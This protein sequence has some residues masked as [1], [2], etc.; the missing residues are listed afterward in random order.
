[1]TAG[2]DADV[3]V[4]GA[5]IAGCSAAWFAARAGRRVTIVDDGAHRASDLPVALINPL[6][7]ATGRLVDGGLAGMAASFAMID[8]LRARGHDVIAGRGLHRPLVGAVGDVACEPYWRARIG[9]RLRFD[10]HA[11]APASLGLTTPVP[12]LF[13]HDAGWVAS[14]TLLAALL[15]ASDATLVS[16]RVASVVSKTA[17]LV[18]GRRITSRTLLWAAGAWGAALLDGGDADDASYRP[19]SLLAFPS[20]A[21]RHA[22]AFGL[23]AVPLDEGPGGDPTGL[24][25]G[26]TRE[27][28]Q[29]RFPDGDTPPDAV[30][31]LHERAGR[32]F[33]PVGAPRVA[34]RGVRLMRLS[35]QAAARLAG[36]VTLTSLGSRGFLMAPLRAAAWARSL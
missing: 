26:P 6:R 36:A 14:P 11:A 30:R 9:D 20:P 5:G 29:P 31:D 35:S 19:G 7:G 33:G 28:S 10:W 22:M 21:V 13:L 1:M 2:A 18:D 25:L 12:A 16:G 3:L 34:W 17:V 23:Y 27:G 8:A 15:A 4:V 32:L 24:L